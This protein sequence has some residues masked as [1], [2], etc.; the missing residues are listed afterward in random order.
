MLNGI[1]KLLTGDVLKVLSDMGHGDEIIIA[2]GNFPVKTVTKNLIRCP[3][4]NVSDVLAAIVDLFP[5]DVTYTEH[6]ACVMELT[7]QDQKKGLPRP[8]AWADYERILGEKYPGIKLGNIER[9]SFYERTKEAYAVILTGED[10]LYGN[11]LLVKG[12]VL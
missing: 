6:P 2:D 12:C 9:F 5:I 7:P 10:R 3:G 1:S 11:L 8:E 4:M